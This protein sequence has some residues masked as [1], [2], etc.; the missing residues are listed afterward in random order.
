MNMG[1]S[2]YQT[3]LSENDPLKNQE[4]GALGKF[5]DYVREQ[6][7]VDQNTIS[8]NN[9]FPILKQMLDETNKTKAW[10][11]LKNAEVITRYKAYLEHVESQLDYLG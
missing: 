4:K 11:A 5:I 7:Q 1:K 6:V 3:I 9:F 2:V 10:K 8:Y